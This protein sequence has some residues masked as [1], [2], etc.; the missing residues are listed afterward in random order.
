[1]TTLPTL[2]KRTSTGKVQEW[3]MKVD[4]D[5]YWAEYGQQGGKIQSGKPTVAKAKNVGK[6]NETTPEDQALKEAQAKWEKKEK[7]HYFAKLAKIDN[8]SF[9]TTLAH[10]SEKHADKLTGE[11]VASSPKLDG[12][13]TYAKKDGLYSREDNKF[14]TTKFIEKELKP[15]FDANPDLVI[16]GELYNHEFKDNFNEIIRLVRRTNEDN[17]TKEDWEKIEKYLEFH[18]FDCIP[19]FQDPLIESEEPVLNQKAPYW[20]RMGHFENL[21]VTPESMPHIKLV[22]QV[23]IPKLD[24]ES[25][26]FLELQDRALKAGYEGIMVRNINMP[27]EMTRSYNLQKVKKFI[28]EEFK[29]V[30]MEEGEGN[31]SG[32]MGKLN[33]ELPNGETF[34]A[35]SRGDYKFYQELWDNADDY[36]GKMATHRFMSYTPDGVPKHGAV[37]AIR[38]YE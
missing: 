3:T 8:V 1:M 22:E 38:D 12:V 21:E 33:L 7:G 16:D 28:T 19:E 29:I 37:I 35:N 11:T 4:G 25:E 15:L 13:R 9:S 14:I 34:N 27:Y 2:Y 23:I 10:S 36:I 24:W 6:S 26:E 32:M 18:I 20:A 17:I 5:K 30:G 31:R